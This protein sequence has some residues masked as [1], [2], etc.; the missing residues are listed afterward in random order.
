M[1]FKFRTRRTQGSPSPKQCG[2]VESHTIATGCFQTH[3]NANPSNIDQAPLQTCYK[4]HPNMSLRDS[5]RKIL[6][7]LSKLYYRPVKNASPLQ[8][9][10]RSPVGLVSELP[11]KESFE[12]MRGAP[13]NTSNPN[14][15]EEEEHNGEIPSRK[16]SA[17]HQ[18][19]HFEDTPSIKENSILISDTVSD[20]ILPYARGSLAPFDVSTPNND[21]DHTP[22]PYCDTNDALHNHNDSIL[23][24]AEDA[25]SFDDDFLS[26]STSRYETTNYNF[27]PLNSTIGSII[28]ANIQIYKAYSISKVNLKLIDQEE[29]ITQSSDTVPI[30]ASVTNN[31]QAPHSVRASIALDTNLGYEELSEVGHNHV[32]FHDPNLDSGMNYMPSE[33]VYRGEMMELVEKHT[34]VVKKQQQ[35]IMHLKSLLQQERRM[36]K[37]LASSYKSKSPESKVFRDSPTIALNLPTH[38]HIEGLELA[39]RSPTIPTSLPPPPPPPRKF[40]NRFLPMDIVLVDQKQSPNLLPP[41]EAPSTIS[42]KVSRIQP[43]AIASNRGSL[44]PRESLQ[45]NSSTF[46]FSALEIVTKSPPDISTWVE[47]SQT[48]LA[49]SME[50]MLTR[51]HSNSSIVSSVMSTSHKPLTTTKDTNDSTEA[52][53]EMSQ[54]L[55]SYTIH[56]NLTAPDLEPHALSS[57]FHPIP[58]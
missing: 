14:K 54:L 17:N 56:S 27:D 51:K 50:G 58:V 10:E 3:A 1:T 52:N 34:L 8:I 13:S 53:E 42:D 55:S 22:S 15:I 12:E 38:H 9:P 33:Q 41:F 7:K 11:V 2:L 23:Q 28:D 4:T 21:Y 44:Q 43:R 31:C 20:I 19:V 6:N 57:K 26:Q 5:S 25:V 35:E 32:K 49:D 47:N 48:P 30:R 39:G 16:R 24:R 46:Y 29:M 37:H 40:R 45:S 18:S 36:T